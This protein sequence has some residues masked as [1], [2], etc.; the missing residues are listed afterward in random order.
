[1]LKF[2]RLSIALYINL[3][4]YLFAGV[5]FFGLGDTFN[6][7]LILISVHSIIMTYYTLSEVNA[8]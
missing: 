6:I 5:I 3:K 2:P 1:M 8:I 7:H 4:F